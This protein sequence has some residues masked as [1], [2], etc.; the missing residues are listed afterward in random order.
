MNDGIT[1]DPHRARVAQALQHI[2]ADTRRS[3][4]THL[5]PLALPEAPGVTL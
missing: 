1:D 5:I 3:A 2:A 4:E